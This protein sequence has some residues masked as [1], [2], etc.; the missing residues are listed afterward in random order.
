[1][2][3]GVRRIKMK[4]KI[5]SLMLVLSCAGASAATALPNSSGDLR[6]LEENRADGDKTAVLTKEETNTDVSGSRKFYLQNFVFTSEDAIQQDVLAALVESY[7]G[8]EVDFNELQQAVNKLTAYLRG[9]GYAVATAFLP[10]QEITDGIIEVK[11]VLGRLSYVQVNNTSALAEGQAE[12]AAGILQ[13]GELLRTDRLET[14]LNN[15][16]DLAGVTAVGVLRAGQANGTSDFVIDL[17]ADKPQQ[18]ILYTDNYGNKYSGRYRY[19]F[20]T[21]INN[22]G[23]IGEKFF[24]GGMLS[25]DNLHNYNFGYEMPVG[26]RGTKMGV[27][28]SL[29]DYTLSG[30]YNILDAVGRAKTFSIYGSTPLI[31]TAS[32]H[33]AAVYGYDNR[34]LKD[35]LRTFGIDTKKHSNALYAGI[36]GNIKGAGSYTGYSALYYAGRLSYDDASSYTEGS[37]HKFNTDVNHIRRLGNVLNLHVN[38]HSQLASKDLDGSEQFVL[39]GANGVRAYPQGEASGDSGYQATAELRYATPVPDLTLAAYVDWG[40]VELSKSYGQHRGL[41]GWGL[42]L[43]Y[44]K[45]DDYYL[46]LDYA[47]KLG[48]E[49]FTSEESDKNGRLW[50]LA[51]KLF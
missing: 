13:K 45:A 19:G 48:S 43:Q 38:F 34:Q 25:N 41:A 6:A 12:K 20:Q 32:D 30:F 33:L 1:M 7:C 31:N 35:E 37:Y 28:Y 23:R 50:F 29:M 36:A 42:G 21:T 40:E 9:Q 44:A 26:S 24:L 3:D 22:P 8:R 5:I 16:N 14:V 4:T 11:I 17:R 51:Y 49:E 2:F 39:G 46:R 15:I 27:S 18:T 47:R 10:Q